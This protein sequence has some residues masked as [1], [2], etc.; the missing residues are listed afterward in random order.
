MEANNV[1]DASIAAVAPSAAEAPVTSVETPIVVETPVVSTEAAPAASTEVVAPISENI[2]GDAP[3]PTE[4]KI[5]EP[6]KDAPEPDLKTTEKDVKPEVPVYEA[7][8]LPEDV[9][10]D[11]AKDTLDT[12]SKLL[13]EIE[14]GKLDHT[15]FQDAGQKLVDLHIQ[16]VQES[17]KNLNDY[18]VTLHEKTG[19]EWLSAF[20]ADPEIGGANVEK[21]VG[22]VRE[23]VEAYAGN[24][25]QKAEFREL[26]KSTNVGKHPAMIRLLANMDAKIR[27]YTTEPTNSMVP[28]ARPAPNK[29]K[30]YQ[31]FYSN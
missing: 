7:F 26:M 3:E 17:V 20:K 25:Q 2:L 24:E 19:T 18:Y 23:A 21:T 8:K 27:Q 1:P 31:R 5:D 6:V 29:V 15:G 9:S 13:G 11:S 12:F 22:N 28:A 10:A 30:D 14:T 16:G 4:K